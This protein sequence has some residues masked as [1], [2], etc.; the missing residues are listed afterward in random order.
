MM[1]FPKRLHGKMKLISIRL[2]GN[3][4]MGGFAKI[5]LRNIAKGFPE[6][7]QKIETGISGEDNFGNE[8][9]INTVGR[10]LFGTPGYMGHIRVS[11]WDG[12]IKVEVPADSPEIVF[13]LLKKLKD[14]IES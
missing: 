5:Y 10:W 13:K 6:Y 8:I 4:P 12:D 2:P 7:H 1:K 3:K 11:N 14:K 9:P